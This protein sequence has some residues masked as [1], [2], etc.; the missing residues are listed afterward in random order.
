MTLWNRITQYGAAL[1]SGRIFTAVAIIA[2]VGAVVAAQG[3]SGGSAAGAR[4][5]RQSAADSIESVREALQRGSP[6]LDLLRI[7]DQQRVQLRQAVDR[8]EAALR[9]LES[10]RYRL[11]E[12][13]SSAFAAD[14]LNPTDIERTRTEARVLGDRAIDESVVT[15]MEA[16]QILTPE[17]RAR[18]VALWRAH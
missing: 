8:H 15:V 10:D 7:T 1:R 18:L 13:F 16:V 6:W 3:F 11:N 9:Q 17:Q 4:H 12:A 14:V 2:V 5:R